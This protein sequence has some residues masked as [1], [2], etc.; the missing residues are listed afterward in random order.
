MS[1]YVLV[2][3][4]WFGS[5]SWDKVIPLL[6]REG[7]T[8]LAP[9]LPGYGN[10]RTPYPEI[11][12]QSFV[13]RVCS[14]IDAQPEPVILVGHSRGGIVITQAAEARPRKIE[15]LVYLCAF[16]PRNGESLL[17]LAQQDRETVIFPH[18]TFAEDQG[19]ISLK[20]EGP[21][22]LKQVFCGD[23][24]DDDA[25]RSRALVSPDALAPSV[26]P[27]NTT[28]A[29]FGSVP[30]VYIE[31]LQDRVIGPA[32]QRQ[33]YEAQPCRRVISMD[34]SHSPFFSA[35]EALAQHLLALAAVPAAAR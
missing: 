34:T 20:D 4:A 1:T 14:V 22:V 24:S 9:D 29:N 12:L 35:P 6:E 25:A 15:T 13:D 30:R 11:T 2:H 8:V 31:A 26:T 33:M 23:C 18:L 16:F 28:D 19:Y 17:H 10:D 32:L 27:V 21:E 5:W 3:G 7:H